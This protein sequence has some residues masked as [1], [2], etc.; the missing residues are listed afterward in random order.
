MR[1]SMDL[2]YLA[3]SKDS[4]DAFGHGGGR[5][6]SMFRYQLNIR[7]AS[8]LIAFIYENRYGELLVDSTKADFSTTAPLLQYSKQVRKK[9]GF[10]VNYFF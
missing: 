1:E 5:R 7:T 10:L 2:S 8:Q 4:N 6:S 3:E 9:K